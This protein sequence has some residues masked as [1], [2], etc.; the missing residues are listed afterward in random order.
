MLI[1][2]ERIADKSASDWLANKKADSPLFF[3]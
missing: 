2:P 3:T 1:P